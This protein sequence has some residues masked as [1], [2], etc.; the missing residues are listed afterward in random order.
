[1]SNIAIVVVYDYLRLDEKLI[2]EEL[3]SRS[4]N[5]VT[6]N[7]ENLLFDVEAFV[8]NGTSIPF[9]G[10]VVLVRSV[11]HTRNTFVAYLFEE[12]GLQVINPYK[13]LVVGNNKFFTLIRL[14]KA[15]LPIPKTYLA[16][17]EAKAREAYKL[18]GGGRVVVKPV[19]GSWGRMVSL[20]STESELELLLRHRAKME[21]PV[22]KLHM[23]Q[24]YVEKPQR[25]IRIIV[26]DGEAVAGIY[27]YAPSC[28]WRTNTAR[29]GVAKPVK[30]DEELR[31]LC[32]KACEVLDAHYAGVDVVE[33]KEGYKILEVNVVPEFKN[34][35]RVTG[36]NIAGKI[37][38]MLVRMCR[39]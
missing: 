1:M 8:G 39:R 37:V 3:K 20:V 33:S 12:C 34:V 29:G 16:F 14:A 9:D 36:V 27:R 7:A 18:L 21:N 22:M 15:G 5:Y 32:V 13:S 17:C 25:D 30:I 2:L 24:E 6:I 26:V 10:S 31:E 4:V 11:S 28:E 23:L 19:S 35:A 38:D